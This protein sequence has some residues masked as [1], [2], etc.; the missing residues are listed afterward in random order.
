MF[1]LWIGIVLGVEVQ[2]GVVVAIGYKD[3][4]KCDLRNINKGYR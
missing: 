1:V 4:G 2:V 3:R